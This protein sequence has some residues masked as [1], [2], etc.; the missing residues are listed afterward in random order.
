MNWEVFYCSLL[1]E[2]ICVR[3]S[4]Y[5]I[6]KHL[7]K[8]YQISHLGLETFWQK[9]FKLQFKKMCIGSFR[10]SNSSFVNFDKL[11]FHILVHFIRLLNL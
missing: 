10:V 11:C 3:L 2:I 8:I 1:S 6:T 7:I 5:F 4:H 9:S